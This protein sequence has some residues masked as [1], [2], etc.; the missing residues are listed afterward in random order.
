MPSRPELAER[1]P[2]RI[3]LVSRDSRH[4]AAITDDLPSGHNIAQLPRGWWTRSSPPP[5]IIS[6]RVSGTGAVSQGRRVELYV[7]AYPELG[8]RR[9]RIVVMSAPRHSPSTNG[10]FAARGTERADDESPTQCDARMRPM[11]KGRAFAVSMLRTRGGVT[12]DVSGYAPFG[13]VRLL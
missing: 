11:R 3:G 6:Y 10:S 4:L 12:L 5:R 9:G 7:L 13:P 2:P 1:V 8:W